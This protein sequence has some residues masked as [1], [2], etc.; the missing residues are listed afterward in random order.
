MKIWIRPIA[1]TM[2]EKF[3]K[4]CHEHLWQNFSKSFVHTLVNAI[5]YL[6]FSKNSQ[7]HLWI[8]TMIGIPKA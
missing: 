2:N 1:Q 8:L 4:F 7:I 6:F 5:S 3:E